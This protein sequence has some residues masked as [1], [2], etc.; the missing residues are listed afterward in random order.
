M[1]SARML[2]VLEMPGCAGATHRLPAQVV[3]DDV[4]AAA[5]HAPRRRRLPGGQLALPR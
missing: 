4:G 2:A 5:A 3:V 1:A